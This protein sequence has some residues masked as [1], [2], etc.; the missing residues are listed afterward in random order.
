MRFN[1][2]QIKLVYVFKEKSGVVLQRPYC[3]CE[4]SYFGSDCSFQCF[5][6]NTTTGECICDPCYSGTAC[7]VMCRGQG[8]CVDDACEC[9]VGWYGPECR[10]QSK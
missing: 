5:F 6:G 3:S 2:G 1:Q 8:T 9:N 7:D 10:V 4:D